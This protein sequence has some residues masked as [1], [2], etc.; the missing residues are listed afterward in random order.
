MRCSSTRPPNLTATSW[1]K[2]IFLVTRAG[3]QRLEVGRLAERHAEVP[4]VQA[5]R[6]GGLLLGQ[7]ADD[8]VA[9]EVERDPVVVAAGELAAEPGHVEVLRLVEVAGRDGQV[10]GVVG[11][12]A[13]PVIPAR[14]R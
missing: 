3:V 9:E 13:S 6:L 12:L 7:V 14:R 2:G 10:E 4:R 1:K 5:L 11:G 8:L